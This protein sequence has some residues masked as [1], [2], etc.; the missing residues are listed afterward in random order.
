MHRH[1]HGLRVFPWGPGRI[2]FDEKGLM[3]QGSS[4]SRSNGLSSFGWR[5]FNFPS[6]WNAGCTDG[7]SCSEVTDC[8][9]NPSNVDSWLPS[10]RLPVGVHILLGKLNIKTGNYTML[11]K[12][13]QRISEAS[14]KFP[15]SLEVAIALFWGLKENLL[16]EMSANLDFEGWIGGVFFKELPFNFNSLFCLKSRKEEAGEE[17]IYIL[18]A[19][20]FPGCT[21]PFVHIYT[22]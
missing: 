4:E 21:W 15:N 9:C 10:A 11:V 2:D 3:A 18:H 17:D 5:A 20:C 13:Q 1:T 16:K 14:T 22:Y 8:K 6:Q 12:L 7:R 19:C